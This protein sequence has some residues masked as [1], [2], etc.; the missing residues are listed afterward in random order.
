[1]CAVVCLLCGFPVVF[2]CFS[3]AVGV[4]LVC[5][6]GAFWSVSVRLFVISGCFG[7]FFYCLFND[8]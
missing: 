2:F 1:M 4:R 7:V 8:F 6:F 5:F 3:D